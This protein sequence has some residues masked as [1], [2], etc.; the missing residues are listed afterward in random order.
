MW[1]VAE[2]NNATHEVTMRHPDGELMHLVIPENNRNSAISKLSYLKSQTDARDVV[3]EVEAT[4][5]LADAKVIPAIKRPWRL[6]AI[7][8]AE[9]IA[10]ILLLLRH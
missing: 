5:K 1:K 9:A 3:K 4:K 6:Y 7:I 8:V 10:I 2:I